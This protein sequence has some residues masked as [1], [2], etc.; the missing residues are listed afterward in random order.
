MQRRKS[1]KKAKGEP[2]PSAD[3]AS[4]TPRD[5]SKLDRLQLL[6]LLDA[7]VR[8]NTRLKEELAEAKRQLEDRRIA[9]DDS[10]SLAHAALRLSGIFEDA[11]RA[12]DLYRQNTTRANNA[13][14]HAVPAETNEQPLA[15]DDE[16]AEEKPPVDAVDT[17]SAA[18]KV[19]AEGADERPAD[20]SA[21]HESDAAE[22]AQPTSIGPV[23]LHVPSSWTV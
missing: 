10:E 13:D 12:I 9:L 20:D 3:S 7:A 22:S 15:D 23:H 19:E 18:G 1:A 17:Q 6:Q 11:Q 4:D 2:H 5:L 21:E 16:D 8:E 14:E